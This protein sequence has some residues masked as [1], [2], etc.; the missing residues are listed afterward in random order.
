MSAAR[1]A[2]VIRTAMAG[3]NK[4]T[5]KNPLKLVAVVRSAELGDALAAAVRGDERVRLEPAVGDLTAFD[6]RALRAKA[7]DI[8]M[9]DVDIGAPGELDALRAIRRDTQ[10]AGLPIIV[11]AAGLVPLQIRR[12]LREGV[13]DF[14]PQPFDPADARDALEVAIAKL[15]TRATTPRPG[16]KI[17]TFLRAAGGAGATTLAVNTALGLIRPTRKVVNRVCL[18]DFDLQFGT[19]ALQLDLRVGSGLVDIIGSPERLDGDLLRAAMAHHDSGLAM[20]TAPGTLM[21]LE[22]LAPEVVARVLELARADHDYVVLDMPHALTGWTDAVLA[23]S[24]LIFLVTQLNVPAVRQARRLLEILQE[25][26]HYSL[27]LRLVVNRH[28][29][30]WSAGLRLHQAE[31]A[32]ERSFDHRVPDDPK[33]VQRALNEGTPALTLRRRSRFGKGLRTL[34]DA[35]LAHKGDQREHARPAAA[36]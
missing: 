7:P 8:L 20:L 3:T 25:E 5:G 32:L 28:R 22:A 31:K 18:I 6:A 10:A 23:A 36:A 13:D 34:V 19:A 30:L 27:P 35:S 33:L 15:R 21:P 24:D 11:T 29:R 1:P 17:I 2:T 12:L 26:G 14:L 9:L 4:M 16:G